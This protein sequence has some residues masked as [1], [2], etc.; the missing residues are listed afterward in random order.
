M[1]VKHSLTFESTT[2]PK[3]GMLT[4]KAYTVWS[5]CKMAIV[6]A[7]PHATQTAFHKKLTMYGT[8]R[9]W[10]KTWVDRF[11][12]TV[13]IGESDEEVNNAWAALILHYLDHLWPNLDHMTPANWV[14]LEAIHQ[15]TDRIK[16]AKLHAFGIGE[17]CV[18][19]ERMEGFI[20]IFEDHTT[21]QPLLDWVHKYFL[22][23]K[24][25][26]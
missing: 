21:E 25:D 10:L 5:K 12:V 8:Q 15:L 23:G 19:P 4:V 20:D 22:T 2:K 3:D 9:F 13:S 6:T 17:T 24:K 11:K 18:E 14:Q 1:S 26:K 16:G 7:F